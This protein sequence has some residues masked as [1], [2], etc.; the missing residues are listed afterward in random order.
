MRLELSCLWCAWEWDDIADVLHACDEEDETL[1][2]EAES[3]MRARAES[4]CVEIP[5]HVFHWD[6]ALLYF[7]HEFA[8]VFFTH[9]TSDNLSYLREEDAVSYTHLTLPTILRV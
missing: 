5:P 4:A 8:V 6:I 7:T 3:T 2:S 1:K 9:G